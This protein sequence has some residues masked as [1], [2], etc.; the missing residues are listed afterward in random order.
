VHF[1][2]VL[3]EIG[4]RKCKLTLFTT[5]AQ[6]GHYM[7]IHTYQFRAI[8]EFM[9]YYNQKYLGAEDII[10]ASMLMGDYNLGPVSS[11]YM[12]SLSS[13]FPEL[14]EYSRTLSGPPQS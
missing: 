6:A 1:A 7:R 14:S 5:H 11:R 3:G 9:K 2:V 8:M 12:R 4:G 10:V 13:S